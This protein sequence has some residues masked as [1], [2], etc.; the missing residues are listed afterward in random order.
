MRYFS[1]TYYKKAT[2]Q[3]DE[4]IKILK[5]LKTRD[6]S[7]ASVIMDF[8]DQKIIKAT[9]D[10]DVVAKDWDTIVSYY[11]E[12]YKNVMERLF[13]ENGHALPT[14]KVEVSVEDETITEV[15]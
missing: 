1:I 9:I 12:H 13:H 3:F 6:V 5:N 10:G 11:Y 14:E 2:G 7:E 8:R 4:S 15:N